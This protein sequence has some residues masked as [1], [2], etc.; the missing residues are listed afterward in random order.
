MRSVLLLAFGVVG[1]CANSGDE[2]MLILGNTAQAAGAVDC[3]YTGDPSQPITSS[4]M[5]S[6][7]SPMGYIVSPLIQSRI[8]SPMGQELTRTIEVQGATVELSIPNGSPSVPLASNESAFQALFSVDIAPQGTAN[9]SFEL[10]PSSV[11]QSVANLGSTSPVSVEV[12]ANLT[13]FG[14]MGGSRVTGQPWQYPVTICNDCVV[15]DHGPCP[16]TIT[17]VRTGDPCNVYQ[18]GQ[19]DC[20]DDPA[21]GLTCP[22]TTM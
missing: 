9:V 8:T 14:T 12:V 19:V 15:V 13:L 5:I 7:A 2:P 11:I 17:L 18:D 10:I 6:V 20:C 21:N 4:G 1:A 3:I 16:L 22:G